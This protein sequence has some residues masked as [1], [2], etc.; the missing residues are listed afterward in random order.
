MTRI[1]L[2]GAGGKMG[3]RLTDNFKK[4]TY[5]Q[6]D[7]LE[8][9]EKGIQNLRERNAFTSNEDEAIRNADVVILA[10][11]D[12]TIGAVSDSLVPR[13]KPGSLVMT[14]DPAAPLD[15]VIRHR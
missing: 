11:P 2:V 12:V 15:G 6:V 8:V 5:Y 4:Q 1:A 3:C 10:V 9:S 14:L 13:M 7:Y